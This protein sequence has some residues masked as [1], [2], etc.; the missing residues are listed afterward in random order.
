MKKWIGLLCVLGS[1]SLWAA[2]QKENTPPPPGIVIGQS[3]RWET[4]YLGSPSLEILADGTYVASHDWFGKDSGGRRTTIYES[5]DQGK[6]WRTIGEFPR[7]NS[8]SLFRIGETLYSIG[9]CKPGIPGISN[10]CIAIRRSTDGGRT[11]STP[12]DAQSGLIAS[13]RSYYADPVPVLFAKGRVWWQIDISEKKTPDQPWP[14]FQTQI[15]SAPVESDLLDAKNWTRSNIVEWVPHPCGKGW[16][17]G[18]VVEAPNG[19][20]NVFMRVESLPAKTV[21]RLHLSSDGKVLTYDPA[22]DLLDFPGGS[23]KFCIRYDEISRK[24]WSLTNLRL[25]QQRGVRSTLALVCS[26]DLETWEVR[27]I[28]YQMPLDFGNEN[29]FQYCDWRIEGEDLIFVCRLGWYGKNFHD[30]NYITMDRIP[31]FRHRTR[32]DDALPFAVPVREEK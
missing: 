31:H 3:D 12:T 32:A 11:W 29:G 4:V 6:T 13:D 7:Q 27:S 28:I 5:K 16:L 30:S 19:E 21:A 9:F 20:L 15:I 24:Y 22:K 1:V 2:P 14:W 8:G 18:N 25:P 23:S 10:E 17:E 26:D